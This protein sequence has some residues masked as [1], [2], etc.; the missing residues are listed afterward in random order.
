[1]HLKFS[2]VLTFGKDNFGISQV[3]RGTL[4]QQESLGSKRELAL[5][6]GPNVN[7]KSFWEFGFPYKVRVGWGRS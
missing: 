7:F 2:Q 1:L 3:R 6:L 5:L 4:I